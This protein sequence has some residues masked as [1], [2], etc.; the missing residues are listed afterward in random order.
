MFNNF[1]FSEN[2][3]VY[4]I[5]WKK[6]VELEKPQMII[7]RMRISRCIPE[8]TNTFSEYVIFIAF[9]LQH[10]LHERA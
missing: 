3:A 1:F 5:M 2:R 4:E 10:W 6:I 8:T 7:W 9:P